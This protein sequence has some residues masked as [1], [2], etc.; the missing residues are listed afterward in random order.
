MSTTVRQTLRNRSFLEAIAVLFG[1]GVILEVVLVALSKTGEP[2]WLWFLAGI[3]ALLGV[4]W[5]VTREPTN[6]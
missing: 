2:E 5:L 3:A 1:L 6:L 4:M